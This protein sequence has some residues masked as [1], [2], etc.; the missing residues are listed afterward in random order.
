[1][2]TAIDLYQPY[3]HGVTGHVHRLNKH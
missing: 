3:G 1:M 2:Q